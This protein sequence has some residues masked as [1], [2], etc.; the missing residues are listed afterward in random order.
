MEEIREREAM[1]RLRDEWISLQARCPQA[2]PFQTWE[3]CDAWMRRLG[4]GKQP[5]LLLFRARQGGELIGIAPLCIGRQLGTPVRRLTWIGAGVS[6]CLGPLV[7]PEQAREVADALLR[8]LQAGR[9]GWDLAD[10]PQLRPDEPLAAL[11]SPNTLSLMEPAPYLNLPDSWEAFLPRLSKKL[12]FNLGYSERLLRR[13]FPDAE[14]RL[15]DPQTLEADLTALFTLHRRRWNARWLPGALHSRRIQA[16]H[17][18]VAAGFLDRGWL[19]LHLLQAGGD[20]RAALYCFAFSGRTYYYQAGFDPEYARFSPGSLLIGKAIRQAVSEQHEE[21]DFL[22]GAE[23]YKYRW[24]PCE[25]V[26][27]RLLLPR[28]EAGV[29][30]LSGRAGLALHRL[31]RGL[32]EQAK[33]LAARLIASSLS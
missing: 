20:V 5:R 11:A 24:Q 16:F 28:R 2:T 6:D 12:R 33:A 14:F 17:H 10:L 27:R 3:W 18:D 32:E 4:A 19:R 22:R 25:R 13:N 9:G 15:A 8:Y 26:H 21:F 7:V 30:A 29:S 1:R 23:P 31:E